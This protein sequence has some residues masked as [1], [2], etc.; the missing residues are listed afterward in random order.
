[1]AKLPAS[2]LT[3]PKTVDQV[4]SVVCALPSLNV[5][6]AFSFAFACAVPIQGVLEFK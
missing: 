3:E 5:P 2:E 4:W 1:V 6:S